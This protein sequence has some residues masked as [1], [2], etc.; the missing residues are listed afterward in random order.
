MLSFDK[1]TKKKAYGKKKRF[2]AKTKKARTRLAFSVAGLSQKPNIF[3]SFYAIVDCYE[4]IKS[5][6]PELFEAEQ[7]L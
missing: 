1:C 7:A 2:F 3:R 5:R 4:F 6:H